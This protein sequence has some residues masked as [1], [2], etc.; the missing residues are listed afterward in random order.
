MKY[1]IILLLSFNLYAETDLEI[2]EARVQVIIDQLATIEIVGNTPESQEVITKLLNKC[3]I[4]FNSAFYY[5]EL[6]KVENVDDLNC[7][8]TKK[9]EVDQDDIDKEAKK[10]AKESKYGE[11]DNFDCTTEKAGSYS[12]L[13]CEARK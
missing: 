11:L 5:N 8:L 10:L 12:R 13:L 4:D 7:F 9:S 6:F 2:E 1:L 3:S